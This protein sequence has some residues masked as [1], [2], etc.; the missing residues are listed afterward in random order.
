MTMSKGL[1]SGE[2]TCWG[3]EDGGPDE[4]GCS[5][6]Q[7]AAQQSQHLFGGTRDRARGRDRNEQKLL[8]KA[9]AGKA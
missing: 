7:G 3:S 4:T 5:W 6:A 2:L 1:E 9:F 8:F